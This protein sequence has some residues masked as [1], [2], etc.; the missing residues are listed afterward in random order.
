MVENITSYH[1]D[2]VRQVLLKGLDH[3]ELETRLNALEFLEDWIDEAFLKNNLAIVSKLRQKLKDPEWKMRWKT[4]K[5]L[6]QN[7]IAFESLSTLDKLR[8]FINP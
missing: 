1:A 5:L 7:K 6:E 2:L 8:R 3:R 4:S